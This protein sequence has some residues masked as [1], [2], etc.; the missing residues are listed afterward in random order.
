MVFAEAVQQGWKGGGRMF[1]QALIVSAVAVAVT[2][3]AYL[4]ENEIYYRKQKRAIRAFI[5][6]R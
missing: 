5:G 6:R 1:R 3:L 2:G 4:V